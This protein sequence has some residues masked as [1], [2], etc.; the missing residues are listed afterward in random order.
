[1]IE[2]AAA[3]ESPAL[4]PVMTRFIRRIM[5]KLSNRQKK[6]YRTIGH[7]LKPVVTL[8]SRGLAPAV[9]MELERALNDHE[10]VKI[11]INADD[12]EEREKMIA[13]VIEAT[14]AV[15][16]QRIGNILLAYRPAADADPALSNLHRFSHVI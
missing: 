10:L 4:E 13:E 9:L 6:R 3:V 16:I 15:N 5:M 2:F 7:Q 1:M 11:K 14:G 12:R 8:A